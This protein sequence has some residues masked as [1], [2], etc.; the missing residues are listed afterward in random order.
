M[1]KMKITKA[2]NTINAINQLLRLLLVYG[3][4][5]ILYNSYLPQPNKILMLVDLNCIKG[6]CVTNQSLATKPINTNGKV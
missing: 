6:C 2:N 5:N 1:T 3:W 4:T